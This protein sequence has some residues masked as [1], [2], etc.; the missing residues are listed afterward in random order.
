MRPVIITSVCCSA[1]GREPFKTGLFLLSRSNIWSG[2][3]CISRVAGDGRGEL[4]GGANVILK[5]KAIILLVLASGY[6]YIEERGA[7]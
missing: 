4:A 1:R 2:T 3:Q 7:Q 5:C 6:E